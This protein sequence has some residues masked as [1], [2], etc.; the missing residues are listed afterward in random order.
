MPFP[1]GEGVL[2]LSEQ[3]SSAGHAL[4]R[5][6]KGSPVPLFFSLLL[7]IMVIKRTEE[8]KGTGDTLSRSRRRLQGELI[9]LLGAV[10]LVD[11]VQSGALPG[12]L[13]LVCFFH[14]GRVAEQISSSRND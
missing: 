3:R 10:L 11:A 14:K 5:T 7:I 4:G 2:H 8:G 1:R 13:H 6:G 12:T 9:N